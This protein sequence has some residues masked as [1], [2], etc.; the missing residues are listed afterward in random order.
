MKLRI[1]K[2]SIRLRLSQTDINQLRDNGLVSVP[3]YWGSNEN[4]LFM[5]RLSV[6]EETASGVYF[7]GD[8]IH[9][10]VN[11]IEI[12]QWLHDEQCVSFEFSVTTAMQALVVLIERDFKCLTPR[13]ENEEDLFKNPN[14]KC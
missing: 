10:K 13:N 9:V 3:L 1:N 12:A 11:K 7:S 6:E 5:Y 8:H 2:Q 14:D 4:D